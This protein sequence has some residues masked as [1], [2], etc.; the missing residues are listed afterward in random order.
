LRKLVK[1]KSKDAVFEFSTAVASFELDGFKIDRMVQTL[2]KHARN[3]VEKKLEKQQQQ[4][5]PFSG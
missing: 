1:Y 2:R 3:V 5:K 4:M